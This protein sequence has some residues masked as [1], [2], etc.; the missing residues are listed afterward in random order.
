MADMGMHGVRHCCKGELSVGWK[1][2]SVGCVIA[3]RYPGA[4]EAFSCMCAA[5]AS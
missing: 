5:S 4:G 3:N 1:S 2:P